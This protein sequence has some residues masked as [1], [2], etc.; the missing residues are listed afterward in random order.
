MDWSELAETSGLGIHPD[1]LHKMGAGIRLAHEAGMLTADADISDL[2]ITD[3]CELQTL[4][5]LRNEVNATYR[6]D[7][8]SEA[9]RIAVIQAAM[10]L[11]KIDIHIP[12]TPPKESPRS[13]VLAMGDF[14]F[15]AEWQVK[16]LYGEVI[17]AYSPEVFEAR[18]ES[19]LWQVASIV[20][21]EE[22]DHIDLM[23]CGDSLDGM[24]RQS[25]L[26]KLRWG[27]VESCMR[28]SEYMAQWIAGLAE[29]ASV[30]VHNVDGN[31]GEIR[32][33]GSKRG[34]FSDENLEK[35]FAWYLH[36]RLNGC[37]GIKV[38]PVS[39]AMKLVEVQ[40]YNFLMTHGNDKALDA[41]AKQTMLLYGQR[42]DYFLCAH[43]HRKQEAISGYTDDG[44]AMTLR[45]PSICG[46]D[47]YA[48]SLG[49]GGKPGALALVMEKGYGRRCVYPIGL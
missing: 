39:E 42:I 24:L 44:N 49:Y 26:M 12:A 3:R 47:G 23:M 8:R 28:L 5:D 1:Q 17:N 22:I 15:G 31:H 21:K 40:G 37:A 43:R 34:E 2:P 18:M 27:V 45:V 20:V 48:K 11:P 32:P 9:L 33:L 13:L 29:W 46:M 25:Q 4:R 14:H 6:A 38:D 16:G 35:V 36:T 41:L 7:A 10:A 19:L 30:S